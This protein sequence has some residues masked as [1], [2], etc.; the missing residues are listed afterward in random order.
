MCVPERGSDRTNQDVWI[1]WIPAV[2]LQKR[3][4]FFSFIYLFFF[5]FILFLFYLFF[6][7][8]VLFH[9]IKNNVQINA[10]MCFY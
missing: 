1:I 8:F 2:C 3:K 4:A 5:Y 10:K 6:F 9:M 7:F